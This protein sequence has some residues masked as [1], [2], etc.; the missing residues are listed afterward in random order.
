MHTGHSI[1]IPLGFILLAG[2]L[3]WH[4][5]YAEGRWTLKLAFI[6]LLV[7]F[8]LEVSKSLDSYAGWPTSE[9][10]PST[11]QLLGAVIR[12]P[13]A[14]T[15]DRGAIIVWVRPLE[16]PVSALFREDP[17]PDE[18]R[19]YRIPY[20]RKMH[21]EVE[22]A[23]QAIRNGQVVGFGRRGRHHG[24]HRSGQP[25]QGQDGAQSDDDDDEVHAYA[26][27]PTQPPPKDKDAA[28]PTQ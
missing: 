2:I 3:C 25:G 19:A 10:L 22:G 20:S 14:Q 18:P 4:L 28:T 23:M 8:G 1:A 27:P 16:P 7:G 6:V 11:G 24:Q 26:L 5:A 21:E 15:G 17:S 13:N 9:D 12:E